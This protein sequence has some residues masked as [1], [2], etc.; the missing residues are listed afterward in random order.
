[1]KAHLR[2]TAIC[3]TP[4]CLRYVGS[5]ITACTR[6][7]SSTVAQFILSASTR[8]MTRPLRRTSDQHAWA[9]LENPPALRQSL[10][11]VQLPSMQAHT[12]HTTHA[13]FTCIV[14]F[15]LRE[16]IQ[17]LPP[18]LRKILVVRNSQFHAR[19]HSSAFFHS[20]TDSSYMFRPF[21]T[22]RK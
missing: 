15:Q 21:R 22:N 2:T 1:M 14:S 4:A 7:N 6:S 5:R 8:L 18:K 17:V 11:F 3:T 19:E 10:A 16:N 12:Y 9:N 20:I 13:Q